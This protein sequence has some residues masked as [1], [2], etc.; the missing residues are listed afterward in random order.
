VD[1]AYW[2]RDADRFDEEVMKILDRDRS[3]VLASAISVA[4]SSRKTVADFGCGNGSLLGLLAERFHTVDAIDHSVKLLDQARRQNADHKNIQYIQADLAD[5]YV[6]QPKVD[7]LVCVNVVIHPDIN[8]RDRIIENAAAA[9]KARGTL[10]CV[11][12]A[13]ESLIHTYQTI[14][15]TNVALGIPRPQAIAEVEEVYKAE[16]VSPVDGIV[17]LGGE[18]TKLHTLT[19]ISTSLADVGLDRIVPHRVEY[20]WD[21]MIDDA[22][23]GMRAPYPWDWLLVA[24]KL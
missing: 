24:R 6:S 18:P 16:I 20:D 15:E 4:S 2:D 21:E 8:V 17:T 7:V 1:K 12:P 11:V 3:G 13:Y 10:I 9:I 5:H 22:P 19:E 23:E 14:V